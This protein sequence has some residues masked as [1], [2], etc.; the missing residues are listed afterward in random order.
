MRLRL[1]SP[2]AMKRVVAVNATA[3]CTM[4]EVE[5][6]NEGSRKQAAWMS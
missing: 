5:K 2:V 6:L 1:S 3:A 4:A